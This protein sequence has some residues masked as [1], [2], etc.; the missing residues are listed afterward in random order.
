PRRGNYRGRSR[1]RS[2]LPDPNATVVVRNL[3]K[4][5][6][7]DHVSEIFGAYGE[8]TRVTIPRAKK[9]NHRLDFAYVDY[10]YAKSAQKAIEH[11]HGGQIDGNVLAVV[12]RPSPQARPPPSAQ[13]PG[14]GRG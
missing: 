2:P 6:L 5:V 9:T 8:I 1:S 11:M 4:N 13:L 7:E 3:T 10:R 14:G 12:L